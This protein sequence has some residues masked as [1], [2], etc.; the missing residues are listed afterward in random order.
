M[1]C[2]CLL[3]EAYLA[4]KA[5]QDMLAEL[6]AECT[7]CFKFVRRCQ[8]RKRYPDTTSEAG[9]SLPL[10]PLDSESP[11]EHRMKAMDLKHLQH[12]LTPNLSSVP[13]SCQ[14][15]PPGGDA[16]GDSDPPYPT[17]I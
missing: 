16:E 1:F 9:S 17:G 12:K 13:A 11:A 6:K 14:P 8:V 2:T 3:R 4:T 5:L 15:E 7:E 10:A